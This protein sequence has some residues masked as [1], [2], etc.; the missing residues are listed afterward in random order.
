MA[1]IEGADQ[2]DVLGQQH[3][4]AEH[5]AG[6]IAD[7]DHGEVLLLAVTAQCTEVALDRLPRTTRGDA[8]A[9]VVVADRT[10][11][12]ERVVQPETVRT[13]NAV[14]GIGERGGALVGSDDQV[15]I[16][17]VMTHH[18]LRRHDLVVDDVVGDVEQ[19]VD[20]AL[21]A[22]HA[23]GEPCIAVHRRIRQ[24]LGEE[25]A[26]G[27]DRHDH[28]VLDHLCLDQTQHLGAEVFA[29]VRPAQAATGNR[30]E[31]QMGTFH[32]RAAHEDFAV[33]ARLG[34][35]RHLGGVELEADVVS[36]AT[37]GAHAVLADHVIAG[38]QGGFDHADEAAQ[39]AVF[40]QAGHAVQQLD[41]H[42]V[43]Q[44]HA[45]IAVAL[46][47]LDHALE[48]LEG[49][50]IVT[51]QQLELGQ[52][53]IQHR[54]V[55]CRGRL[56][57]GFEQ[58]HDQ[59]R[60]QR[61]A[62][63]GAFHISL[64]ERHADLQQVLAVATQHGHLAPVQAGAQ[65]QA[66]EAVVLGV[67]VPDACEGVAEGGIGIGRVDRADGRL[68]FE[69]L[70]VH[71]CIVDHQLVRALRH[72]AQAHVFH[73]RQHVGQ[74]D[75]LE[76]AVQLQAQAV[77][78]VTA[79]GLQAQAQIVR[80]GQRVQL[81]HVGRS[82]FSAGVFDI[83]CRQGLANTRGNAQAFAF[84]VAADQ[85]F[86]QIVLPVAQHVG[87]T[88]LHPFHIQLQAL[89]GLGAHDQ[90]HLGQRRVAQ[91]HAGIDVFA[92]QGVLQ[93]A[94]HAQAHVGVEALARQ[95][96]QRRDEAT[97]L[98][99]AQEQAATHA[100]LQAQHAHGGAE[101]LVLAGLEQLFARQRLQDV[102]QCLAAV[103]GQAQARTRHH[104][105]I[106]L[107][108]QRDFPRA[109]VVG[110][111][112]EQAKEALLADDLALGVEFQHA[113]VV[114]VAAAVDMRAGIGLGQDQRIVQAAGGIQA[115]GRQALD[116][117][118]DHGVLA[119][120]QAQAG[121]VLGNQHFFLALLLHLVFAVAEESEM[122]VGG[123]AQELLRF[124]ARGLA[125]RQGALA[126]VL[127]QRQC[128]VG[129]RLPV[130]YD[131]A[132]VI[133]CGGHALGN[134][135]Q[136]IGRLAID[137][138]QH[139]RFQL[140]LAHA[141]ELAGLVT[142]NAD[143][144]MAQHMHA[145]ALLGQRQRYRV[146]QE[147]HV[148][149]DDLQHGVGRF[150]AIGLQRRVEHPHIGL[151]RLAAAGELQHAGGQ[152]RPVIGRVQGELVGLHALVERRSKRHCLRL[153]GRSGITLPQGCKYRF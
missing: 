135:I 17:H 147:R 71:R 68:D 153:R 101:Q 24:L 20:E 94:F 36:R 113:D 12:G 148:V 5:V 56:E 100:L 79:G 142:A 143:H 150:P 73:H 137:L 26:L 118:R 66:V 41:Q 90:V 57:A 63:E 10:T 16:V 69:V 144:R 42:L 139:H 129:H 83:T 55:A 60:Q 111:G 3:A 132:H 122:V 29:T 121:A 80:T 65:H 127:G 19:A 128:L 146:H 88:L 124:G 23:L 116:R 104:V 13:G 52:L 95:E 58:F 84:A 2:A 85:R 62:V 28:G 125:Y 115:F 149:V 35:V 123:P 99:A 92:L 117:A 37:I 120:H 133:Q 9:L 46:A 86:A 22:G 54:L 72:H 102:A 4:V 25:A 82:D 98:V 130:I 108:H 32:T 74:R 97:E 91:H 45:R 140:A 51:G 34:Q 119:A 76:L 1:V 6:H 43:H 110:A 39:D 109:A 30:A 151:A 67:A 96:H 7:A 78:V 53:C 93:H 103:A 89:T 38:T 114:H 126:Q 136:R 40:V 106:A 27:A 131:G 107:A 145:D 134:G 77:D 61:V 70:H 64:R 31:A 48:Q 44:R 8:H 18:A 49:G 152:H 59:A 81:G 21:V 15:R 50:S 11:R 87:Q 105:F 47:R 75:V 33:R 112:G 14:G 138:Q 141:V